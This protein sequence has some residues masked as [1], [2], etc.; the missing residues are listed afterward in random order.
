M[1]EGAISDRAKLPL[2]ACRVT[3]DDVVHAT[4]FADEAFGNSRL[5]RLGLADV[6]KA[7]VGT[8]RKAGRLEF[9]ASLFH[10]HPCRTLTV[11]E[12]VSLPGDEKLF[13]MVQS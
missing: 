3:K 2:F 5:R 6:C 1:I 13:Q 7:I 8:M 9:L 11:L 12:L 4:R 10:C